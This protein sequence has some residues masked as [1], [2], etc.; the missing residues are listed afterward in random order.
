[1]TPSRSPYKISELQRH[2]TAR[3]LDLLRSLE[4]FRLLTTG[5]VRRLHFTEHLTTNSATRTAVR[6]LG[7]LESHGLV[8][9]LTRRIG[10]IDKGSSA[11]A[12]QL[13]ATGERLLRA[14]AGDPNRRRFVEPSE[15][16]MHHTLAV[17]QLALLIIEG[18]RTGQFEI[19]T[20]E[21]EPDCWRSWVGSAGTVEWLKP[22][23]FLVTANAAFEAHAFVEIDRDTE[24]IPAIIRKCQTY[25]RYWNTGIE[26]ARADLFP[27][28]VWVV[29]TT[30]RAGRIR[31][32]IASEQS[33][34]SELFH[35]VTRN[36]A[37][38][39]LG[40]E[41]TTQPSTQPKGG[42]L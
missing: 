6:V 26:Q 4:Q 37:L 33:L 38:S 39:V 19:L 41:P 8:T 35:V 22:D 12:W 18:A 21:T 9:R 28:V 27:A 5:Q 40:P 14:L 42:T 30:L 24:H 7:R 34:T 15:P 17:A 31:T 1:M 20:Q 25:Q 10:G 13:A 3:D 2:L 23:L 16:F 36:E 11:N 29:P 32:A